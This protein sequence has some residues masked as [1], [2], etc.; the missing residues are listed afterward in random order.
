MMPRISWS[1][2]LL[3]TLASSTAFAQEPTFRTDDANPELPWFR[4][5]PGEFPA[6]GSAHY[7]GGELIALDR[8]NRTGTVRL[9][10]TDAQ[11]RSAWDRL[12]DFALLPYG[13][14]RFQ[15]APAELRDIPLGTHLHG[16]Y[17]AVDSVFKRF[18]PKSKKPATP[19]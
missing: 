4:L 8:I 10:R 11:K 19:L 12:H 18:D 2:L 1:I 15:G 14:V 3:S 17:Y 6:E 5:K 9:D 7:I 16:Y 13:M